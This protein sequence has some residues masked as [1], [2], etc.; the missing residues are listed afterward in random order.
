MMY[1]KYSR[2]E[3]LGCE[4]LEL[5]S[6]GGGSGNGSGKSS[7]GAGGAGKRLQLHRA[8]LI[9]SG[10]R[11]QLDRLRGEGGIHKVQRNSRS[12]QNNRVH[13]STAT[14]AILSTKSAAAAG[15]GPAPERIDPGDL[16][17]DYYRG[18][19][20]GG[21]HRNKSDTAVRITHLPTGLV[22]TADSRSQQNNRKCALADIQE[23]LAQAAASRDQEDLRKQRQEFVDA[24]KARLA[25]VYDFVTDTVFSPDNRR[26]RVSGVKKVLS[27]KELKELLY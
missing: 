17:T 2:R 20:A 3:G 1:Q 16:R 13:T 21:Q 4:L 12:R 18:R 25:R 9:I 23:Q 10:K 24:D 7:I 14:V 5:S 19:G 26:R 8:R 27:G 22:A 6:P 15:L 11:R